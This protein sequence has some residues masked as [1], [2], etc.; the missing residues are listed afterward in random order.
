[1][2]NIILDAEIRGEVAPQPDELTFIDACSEE[3][4]YEVLAEREHP[5]EAGEQRPILGLITSDEDPSP[6]ERLASPAVLEM[7]RRVMFRNEGDERRPERLTCH[8][9]ASEFTLE[10]GGAC[11]EGTAACRFC[12]QHLNRDLVLPAI[13][14]MARANLYQVCEVNGREQPA[15]RLAASA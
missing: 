5:G 6:A 15:E 9:C 11:F 2:K 3:A 10:H 12:E 13:D 1:M 8:Y 7:A 4:Y 14:R